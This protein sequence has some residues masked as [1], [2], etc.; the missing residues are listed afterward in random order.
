MKSSIDCQYLRTSHVNDSEK[1]TVVV[2][3]IVE[4][5]LLRGQNVSPAH[6]VQYPSHMLK[7]LA[8]LHLRQFEVCGIL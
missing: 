3:V 7:F 8:F 5:R 1:A 6:L 4:G 2:G